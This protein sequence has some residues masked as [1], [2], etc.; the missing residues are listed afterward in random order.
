MRRFSL[1]ALLVLVSGNLAGQAV[2]APPRFEIADVIADIHASAKIRSNGIARTYPVRNGRYEIRSASMVDLIR[3]AWGFDADKILGGP[4]WVEL[5]RFDVIAKVPGGATVEVQRLMLQALLK[6][7]FKLLLHED[8]KPLPAW[9]LTATAKPKLKEADGS[10][11]TGCKQAPVSPGV[12][13]YSCRNMTM[14][15]FAA[16]LRSM[17][18]VPLDGPVIDQTG[19]AGRWNFEVQWS[20]PI[21][22][23]DGSDTITLAD[24]LE[25]QLGLKLEQ[26]PASKPV[27]VVDSVERKPLE[28]PPGVKEALPD[29]PVPTDFEVADVK[30]VETAPGRAGRRGLTIQPGG[31]FTANDVT[32]SFLI[33]RAFNGEDPDLIIGIPGWADSA[34]VSVTAKVPGDYP[35]GQTVD[36]E[37]IGPMLRSL[38]TDRFGLAWHTEQ[39][40]VPMQTLVASRPKLKKADPN[41]RIFCRS[42]APA[43]SQAPGTRTLVCQN[44]TMALFAERLPDIAQGIYSVW[45]STGIEGGWDFTL[46][47]SPYPA[48]TPREPGIGG[49]QLP[50]AA[51]PSGGS[52]IS[53]AAE[54]QLGLKLEVQKRMFPVTVIDKLNQ[55]PAQN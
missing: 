16:G 31:R 37:I 36:P 38:L 43:P 41:S 3:I 49:D 12:V 9:A 42:T 13:R 39:R 15:A 18:G 23:S 7:R 47:Y 25:R 1:L 5:D 21:P 51:E 6:E 4:N 45:D 17:A 30:L 46:S 55:K 22:I 28:N 40:M 53:Q 52:T 8:T 2:D 34:H 44:A 27:L 26:V 19:I 10:G 48:V 32:L 11:D 35:A 54:K 33:R 24:A 14:T 29:I 20:L 50:Q